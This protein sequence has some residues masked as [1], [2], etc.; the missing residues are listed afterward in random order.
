MALDRLA[1]LKARSTHRKVTDETANRED[2]GEATVLRDNQGM[3]AFWNRIRN[4]QRLNK[5]VKLNMERQVGIKQSFTTNSSVET[6]KSLI[7]EFDTLQETNMAKLREVMGTIKDLE[8][9]Y[10]QA[11]ETSPEEPETRMKE[12]QILSISSQAKD[13]MKTS[14]ETSLMFKSIVKDKLK[15]QVRNVQGDKDQMS[16]E[17]LDNLI[18]KDPEAVAQMMEAK[19]IGMPHLKVTNALRDIQDKCKEIETLHSNVR[20]LYEMITEIS[21]MVHQQGQQVDLILKNV[22]KAKDYVDKGN[23][24]LVKAKEYHQKAR[25]KQCCIIMVAVALLCILLLPVLITIFK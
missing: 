15:R 9:D 2:D 17:E 24:N 12:A 1:E 18:E 6:E 11:L 20:K 3:N 16:N 25:K 5:E 21:E 4:C 13:L 23:K 8:A 19:V 10:R 22:E 7:T 14:Q